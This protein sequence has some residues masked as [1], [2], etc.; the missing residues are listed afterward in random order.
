[1]LN[2]PVRPLPPFAFS[3]SIDVRGAGRGAG[4]APLLRLAGTHVARH[5]LLDA[6]LELP[7]CWCEAEADNPKEGSSDHS[8]RGSGVAGGA[9]GSVLQAV[10]KMAEAALAAAGLPVLGRQAQAFP[11]F[12]RPGAAGGDAEA[13][14]TPA[15]SN[16]LLMSC[17]WVSCSLGAQ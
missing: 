11:S 2:C 17:R 9:H 16:M 10:G 12:R 14:A 5:L 8:G 1:M 13:A 3:R 4:G 6:R 7:A 15:A